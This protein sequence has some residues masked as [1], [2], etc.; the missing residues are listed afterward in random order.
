MGNSV[1]KKC[2][3]NLAI[4]LGAGLLACLP[5]QA[6]A[7]ATLT[8]DES[9]VVSILNRTVQADSNGRF[10][11][12]NVPSFMGKVKARATCVRDGMT[13]SGETDYFDVVTN[14]NVF[15]GDFF[16]QE[17]I[18]V[19]SRIVINSGNALNISGAG[20]KLLDCQ[21]LASCS[22]LSDIRDY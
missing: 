14:G 2:R 8:V 4:L 7:A 9:C 11:M 5:V 16:R 12:P 3:S 6:S 19:S 13:V 22:R 18:A 1:L 20:S 10:A 17:K 15:V 21:Q